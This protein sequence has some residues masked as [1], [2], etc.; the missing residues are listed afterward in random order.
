MYLRKMHAGDFKALL[1]WKQEKA[2]NIL[3]PKLH[4]CAGEIGGI[5]NG[6]VCVTFLCVPWIVTGA[7][8]KFLQNRNY[9]VFFPHLDIFRHVTFFFF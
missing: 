5:Y 8:W 4:H 9:R 1:L 7:P 3:L 2:V 6:V